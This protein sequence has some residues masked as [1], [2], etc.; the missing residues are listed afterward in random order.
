MN[1][2]LDS[3]LNG[4]D[5]P[6]PAAPA[7]TP[8]P[9][10]SPSRRRALPWI[11]VSVVA[12][13]VAG[14]GVAF[15]LLGQGESDA[16]VPATS[17]SPSS[18]PSPSTEPSPEPEAPAAETVSLPTACRDIFSPGYHAELSST[19]ASLSAGNTGPR[20]RPF[21]QSEVP[22]VVESTIASAPHL[23]C[24]W[25]FSDNFNVGIHTVVAEI[26]DEQAVQ[27]TQALAVAG[28]AST[29]ELGSVRYIKEIAGD[30]GFGPHGY[31]IIAR[32]GLLIATEWLD[33]PASGYTADIVNTVL[34]PAE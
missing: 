5:D 12:L 34:G 9:S 14:G 26:T 21:D 15:A 20:E 13:L 30:E 25:G 18:S 11:V 29:P 32:D 24:A 4:L 3:I 23:E 7:A 6:E 22:A 19:G 17:A 27:V 31:S 33:W 16:A 1:N 2:D 8:V 10:P 28:F